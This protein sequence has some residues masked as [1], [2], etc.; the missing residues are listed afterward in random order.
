[1]HNPVLQFSQIKSAPNQLTLLRLAFVPFIASSVVDGHFTRA[2]ILFMLAGFSD[3]LDGFLAR[4]FNQRTLLG[5]YLDPIADKL[6]LSTMFLVLSFMKQIPWRVTFVVFGR[7]LIILVVCTL[8]YITTA[9]RDFRPTIWGKLNTC[10]QIATIFF[11]LLRRVF[12][13][14]WVIQTKHVLLWTTF[15]LTIFS[16]LHYVW[17]V[18]RRLRNV[19]GAHK[20][21]SLPES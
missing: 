13:Q 17:L 14:A 7:D 19:P 4:T 16:A 9:L 11:A 2:L 6:L 10:A 18:E 8:L 21:E 1:V 3:G 15:G 20:A 12:E 5:Q